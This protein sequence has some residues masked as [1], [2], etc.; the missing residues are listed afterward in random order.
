MPCMALKAGLQ[1]Q[2]ARV[3]GRA[4]GMPWGD[5][6]GDGRRGKAG[7]QDA[8]PCRSGCRL[9]PL[10]PRFPTPPL[11][12]SR[13]RTTLG[14]APVLGYYAATGPRCIREGLAG[15]DGLDARDH[16]GLDGKRFYFSLS[17]RPLYRRRG[18]GYGGTMALWKG[19]SYCRRLL[20]PQ[21][22]RM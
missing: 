3:E 18:K 13:P 9:P 19:V 4:A 17:V 14:P 2:E 12:L 1:Y 22:I 20:C 11:R 15:E 16:A 5:D 8:P 7:G 6:R 21:S 10:P